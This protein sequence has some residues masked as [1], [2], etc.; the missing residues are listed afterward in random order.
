MFCSALSV[1]PAPSLSSS[2]TLR[3]TPAVSRVLARQSRL[4]RPGSRCCRRRSSRIGVSTSSS[5]RPG[6]S[7]YDERLVAAARL[8][9]VV[10]TPTALFLEDFQ[11]RRVVAVTGSKGKTTTAMLTAAALGAYGL[12]VALAGNL[13]RPLTELYDDGAHDV[14][15]VELSSF[16]AAD[17]TVSPSVGVLDV[18]RAGPPRLASQPHELLRGQ[19]PLVLVSQ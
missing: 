6:V 19:A 12:D 1:R 10:T 7:R 15:V 16:Q 2:T 17:V 14:F 13:G 9:A 18:A 8:G 4:N 5:T 11:D 3:G